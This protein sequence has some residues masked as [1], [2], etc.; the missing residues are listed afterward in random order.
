MRSTSPGLYTYSTYAH[1]HHHHHHHGLL[2]I[3]T[4]C[5]VAPADRKLLEQREEE[6]RLQVRS[7]RQNE[8][9]LGRSN[10][11]LGLKGQQLEGRLA[12][13]EAE[14]SQAREEVRGGRGNSGD[15]RLACIS[16]GVTAANIPILQNKCP[17]IVKKLGSFLISNLIGCCQVIERLT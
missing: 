16:F 5:T 4:S 9:S 11:E 17:T 15:S 14:L 2:L 12:L 8:A 10:S 3:P 7:L 6:L 1:P 13:L